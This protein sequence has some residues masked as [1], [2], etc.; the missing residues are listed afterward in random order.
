MCSFV[1]CLQIPEGT[2]VYP[3]PGQG[4][5]WTKT[6]RFAM[7]HTGRCQLCRGFG[8]LQ[9]EAVKLQQLLSASAIFTLDSKI[10][11]VLPPMALL[12]PIIANASQRKINHKKIQRNNMQNC[13]PFSLM[14]K[15]CKDQWENSKINYVKYKRAV[16]SKTSANSWSGFLP[17]NGINVQCSVQVLLYL[18]SR[19][20]AHFIWLY[21]F[22]RIWNTIN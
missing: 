4:G 11:Q 8:H 21:Y 15:L 1:S 22:V 5:G 7:E 19:N 16:T 12:K 9:Q 3:T 14:L 17:Y 20:E 18:F 13:R 10:P 2:S 6:S